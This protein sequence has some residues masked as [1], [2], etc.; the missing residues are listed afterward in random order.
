MRRSD[1][2]KV[3]WFALITVGLFTSTYLYIIIPIVLAPANATSQ[4]D[5]FSQENPIKLP[6]PKPVQ[7]RPTA[8]LQEGGFILSRDANSPKESPIKFVP[9]LSAVDAASEVRTADMTVKALDVKLQVT[10]AV[11]RATSTSA[12]A[13]SS[14]SSS[15]GDTLPAA[16]AD[17]LPNSRL[18]RQQHPIL[19]SNGKPVTSD[20]RGNL[21]PASVVTS[22]VIADWLKD[23]WQ[24]ASDMGGTPIR[25]QHWLEIDLQEDR[26]SSSITRILIDWEDAFSDRWVVLGKQFSAEESWTTIAESRQMKVKSRSKH[27]VIQEVVLDSRLQHNKKIRFVRLLIHS[28][29]TK[30]GSSVWRFQVWGIPSSSTT[31]WTQS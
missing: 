19:L 27:H 22:E 15:T 20:V 14:S 7:V 21:G 17:I 24:A 3:C 16:E 10:S 31:E 29:S 18:G 25:G 6:L 11:G 8:S 4:P 1:L 30:W 13:A 28:P 23:R 2:A 12:R 9:K 5:T 26:T